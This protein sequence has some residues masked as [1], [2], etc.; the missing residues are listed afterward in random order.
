MGAEVSSLSDLEN[1]ILN[2]YKD[3][4]DYDTRD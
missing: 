1:I 2:E 4:I 3:T